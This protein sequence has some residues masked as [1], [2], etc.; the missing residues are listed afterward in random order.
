MRFAAIAVLAFAV[1][2]A[3][4]PRFR[5]IAKEAGLTH[6]FPNGG[7]QTKEYLIETTGSG[8]AFIDYDNDG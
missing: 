2:A 8:V 4:T 5:D 6:S 7:D 1:T 3:Q